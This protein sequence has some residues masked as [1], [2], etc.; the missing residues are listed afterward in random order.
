MSSG[1][2]VAAPIR[3]SIRR[4][5]DTLADAGAAVASAE[6]DLADADR[7]FHVPRVAAF[8][9]DVDVPI[10]PTTQVRPFHIDTDWVREIDGVAMRTYIEWMRSCGR[11]T[12][13]CCPA[14]SLSCGFADGLPVD[15]QPIGPMRQDALLLSVAKAVEEVAG[16]GD[17]APDLV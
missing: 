1:R 6:P 13:T 7:I 5:G 10:G 17:A 16:S 14:P 3:A 11:L 4:L 9:N 8:F 2:P 12:V 15:A